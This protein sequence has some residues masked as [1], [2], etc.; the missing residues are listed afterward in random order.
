LNVILLREIE[1]CKPGSIDPNFSFTQ[2]T[3]L[4]YLYRGFLEEKTHSSL[5]DLVRKPR[6]N[7]LENDPRHP[8]SSSDHIRQIDPS[9]PTTDASTQRRSD[10]SNILIQHISVIL[11]L[12]PFADSGAFLQPGAPPN[13]QPTVTADFL[14]S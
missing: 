13:R 3:V 1:K 14:K 8:K 6:R 10:I 7:C 2:K 12:H 9:A 11:H 4:T 5:G